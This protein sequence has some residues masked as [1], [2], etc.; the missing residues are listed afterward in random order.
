MPPIRYLI[1]IPAPQ[2]HYAELEVR[3]PCEGML[4]MEVF[5]PVWTPGS[6]LVREYARNLESLRAT[7]GGLRPLAVVKVRKNRWRISST[8]PLDEIILS[9]KLYCH[10]LSVRTNYVDEHHA[11]FI[12]AATFV[13]SDGL[14]DRPHEVTVD[15]PATWQGVW[16]GLPGGPHTFCAP[17]YDTLV[18]CP[19]V[20]GSPSIEQF[21]VDGKPHF[22]VTVGD[23]SLWDLPRAVG[24]VE[25][26]V[27]QHRGMWGSLPYENYFF[28][29]LLTGVKGGLEHC[30]SMVIGADRFTMRTRS[31]Y[32]DWLDLV[33]HEFFHV[34]NVKRL[35]PRELGPFDYE[36]EVYTRNLW[37]AEGLTEYYGL[38]AVRRAGLTTVEEFLAGHEDGKGSISGL[39]GRLQSTPGRLEQSLSAASFDAWIKLYR[40]DEN[41][42]NSTISYYVKGAVAAW[43]LDARIRAATEDLRSL[44][45]LMR[46][47]FQRF[48]GS[49]GFTSE[50][51]YAAAQEVGN[52]KLDE[53]F[54]HAVDSTGEF[55][56]AEA[57]AWFG[58]RFKPSAPL[59]QDESCQTGSG[60][61]AWPGFSTRSEGGRLLV[62]HV[63]RNSPGCEA[64][65]SPG[66]EIL[67]IGD[68]RVLATEWDQRLASYRPGE[69]A[70]LFLARNQHLITL[71]ICFAAEPEKWVLEVDPSA[72]SDQRQRLKAWTNKYTSV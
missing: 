44:D 10:E 19:L 71:P 56:Y 27:R 30:N 23:V 62:N 60:S 61:R 40:P 18:D 45:D 59:K 43:L 52:V 25:K 48:S 69:K 50:E 51:F 46:F 65:V 26:I 15:L 29:N 3:I 28:F 2:S 35:R 37:I 9:Y 11:L 13:T 55:D 38:L 31:S 6:Y 8:D 70:V 14:L 68:Y 47:C 53:W 63:L 34:W 49:R 16:S 5:L 67:G 64:G 32:S 66:D 36:N 33:S 41:S 1:R 72:N 12:G 54:A 17:D 22:V 7:D 58:L 21:A 57:L 4:A 24:D 42:G 20:A 39:I